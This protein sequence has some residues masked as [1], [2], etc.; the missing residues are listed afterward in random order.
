MGQLYAGPWCGFSRSLN[1]TALIR[2]VFASEDVFISPIR[3]MKTDITFRTKNERAVIPG[4]ID[5]GATENFIN[6][7]FA[8]KYCLPLVELDKPRPVRNV[9]S[10]HNQLGCITHAV[11]L[12]L[13]YCG[14]AQPFL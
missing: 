5:S 10:T 1:H 2:T 3:S 12:N 8:R 11:R 6:Y 13:Q 7:K 14:E 9:D 4:L